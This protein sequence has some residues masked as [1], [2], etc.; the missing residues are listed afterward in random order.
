M[1]YVTLNN[2]EIAVLKNALR[3]GDPDPGFHELLVTLGRLLDERTGQLYISPETLK[4]IQ[5]YAG[6]KLSWHGL[7]FGILGRNM[8]GLFARE[9]KGPGTPDISHNGEIGAER[10]D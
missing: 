7:I 1:S 5:A 10:E 3:R 2:V 8:G 6:K 4:T 9:R